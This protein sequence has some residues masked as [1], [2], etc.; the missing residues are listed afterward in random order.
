[1][2]EKGSDEIHGATNDGANVEESATG[3]TSEAAPVQKQASP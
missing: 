2:Y 1:M 3:Q